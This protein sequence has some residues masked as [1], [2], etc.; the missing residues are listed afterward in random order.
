MKTTTIRRYSAAA[1]ALGEAIAPKP[2][3]PCGGCTLC[4]KVIPVGELGLPAFTRCQHERSFPM[5]GPAG[6]AIYATRPSSC[7]V[8][9]CQW[10]LD[11]LPDDLRPDR[12]GVVIDPQ[13]DIIRLVDDDTGDARTLAAV[14][15]W[16]APGFED[17]FKRQPGLAMVLAAIDRY[18]CVVWR[19]RGE[20]GEQVAMSL[21]RHK[22]KLTCTGLAGVHAE[23]TASMS[24]GERLL[25]AQQLID[26]ADQRRGPR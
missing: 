14:Q 5:A 22:G 24:E 4:C 16:A 7:R 17:A 15:M 6:C 18:G 25:R 9:S 1:R 21:F 3:K 23:F 2:V 19:M 26:R 8:W 11:G 20:N 10:A 12:C 13:P